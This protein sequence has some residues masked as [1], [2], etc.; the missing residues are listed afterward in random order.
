MSGKSRPV[1][2][3]R[4]SGRKNRS[5]DKCDQSW[6]SCT[7]PPSTTVDPSCSSGCNSN[8]GKSCGT[9]MCKDIISNIDNVT[10][11]YINASTQTLL[12]F[13]ESLKTPLNFDDSPVDWQPINILILSLIA[14]IDGILA[15]IPMINYQIGKYVTIAQECEVCCNCC[16]I[17]KSISGIDK[18]VNDALNAYNSQVQSVDV[19]SPLEGGADSIVTILIYIILIVV[20]FLKSLIIYGIQ[21]LHNNAV[22]GLKCPAGEGGFN[23]PTGIQI[24]L[25]DFGVIYTGLLGFPDG[26]DSTTTQP[27]TRNID[28][29][30]NFNMIVSET[31]ATTEKKISQNMRQTRETYGD[32]APWNVK[33]ELVISNITDALGYLHCVVCELKNVVPA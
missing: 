17:L 18:K 8:C 6:T 13:L 15:D 24:S 27:I 20:G 3:K 19:N 5:N 30:I 2:S 4:N 22:A 33:N 23:F 11:L 1:Y 21:Q 28:P 29:F 31:K 7:N 25:A 12:N 16:S 32:N 9:L 26:A 10:N 14:V